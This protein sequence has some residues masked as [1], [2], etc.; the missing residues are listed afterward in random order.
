[1]RSDGGSRAR[2][3]GMGGRL[4]AAS[5]R[6]ILALL[7]VNALIW[8]ASVAIARAEDTRRA[9]RLCAAPARG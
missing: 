5:R 4:R 9:G 3:V 2:S 1:M 6:L 8:A 7:L